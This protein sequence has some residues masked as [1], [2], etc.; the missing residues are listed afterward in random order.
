M[1]TLPNQPRVVKFGVFEVD[2]QA[3]EV[4]KA[5][6]RQ[7]L[8]G[9]PFQVLQVLLEHPQEIVTREYLR[10]RI[11]PGNTFVDYE[12]A[13]KKA[14]N[15]LRE[16][17]GDSAESPRFIET[18]PRRGYR[19]IATV[20]AVNRPDPETAALLPPTKLNVPWALTGSLALALIAALLLGFNADKLRTRIFAKSRSLEIRSIAV[21]PLEN[22]S[23]DLNQDYFSDGITDALTTELAQIGSLRVISRTSAMHFRGT[24]ETLPEIGRELNVDAVVEGSITRSENR[25]RITAQLIDAPSDRHLWAKSYERDLKDVLALQDEVARDIAAEIRIKLTP[26]E[27]TRLAAARPIDPE[28]HDAYL[29]GRYF[30]NR[31]TEA[32]LHK[33]KDYFE[34]AI[35]KDPGYAPA[36]SGLADTY[37]YLSY[38]WGHI[39][40]REGMPLARAAALKA[41]ELDDSSAEGHTSLATVKFL[42]DWDVPGAEQEFKRAIALNPNYEVAPH[43]YAVLLAA[44]RRSDEAVAQARKAVE[45]DPL[46]LPANNML[47]GMLQAA[48]RCDEALVQDKKTLELDPN[49]THLG[50]VHRTMSDCYRTKGMEKDAIEEDVTARIA[51][52]ASPQKIEE[53]RN[54]YAHSGHKGILEMNLQESLA[55]WDKDHWHTDA[56]GIAFLYANLG[57]MDSALA[58]IDKCIEL[59]S[60]ILMWIYV[61]DNPF[62]HDPRFAEVKRK[63]G[64]QN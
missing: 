26:E 19:F 39:P 9:Q 18:V 57:D 59:R 6:L 25:V 60:T 30:W 52:G 35:A 29:R 55:R 56:T 8:P 40:P 63:M 43:G 49:P 11:W 27:R 13:L 17:L 47:G 22:L 5:G 2:L 51:E 64:V 7:K 38:A 54:I 16:V 32:D 42:Y 28:A 62:Q 23:K 10:E 44:K 34:Q 53:V 37:F 41:I 3:G 12:L 1:D 24:H 61:G 20:E 48:N 46:S 31:R 58:W 50:L 4:R 33:A 15:R 36:Y 14:V 21:L 45:V